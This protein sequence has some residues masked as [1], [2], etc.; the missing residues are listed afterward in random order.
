MGNAGMS[1]DER[2]TRAQDEWFL[3]RMARK[4]KGELKEEEERSFAKVGGWNMSPKAHRKKYG[5]FGR[6]SSGV[7]ERGMDPNLSREEELL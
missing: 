3:E 1:S 4:K 5:W 6:S 7:E 2:F